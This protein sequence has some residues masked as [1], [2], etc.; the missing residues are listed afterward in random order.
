MTKRENALQ[1]F[2][3]AFYTPPKVTPNADNFSVWYWIMKST[4][5]EIAQAFEDA[6]YPS[7]WNTEFLVCLAALLA[8]DEA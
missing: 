7:A 4:P 3:N 2:G 8:I 1:M 6:T 5:E